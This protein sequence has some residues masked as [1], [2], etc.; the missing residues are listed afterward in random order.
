MTSR[1]DKEEIEDRV[2]T[3][4][5][6]AV[7]SVSDASIHSCPLL[8]SFESQANSVLMEILMEQD[9]HREMEWE[10]L[11]LA[12]RRCHWRN[13]QLDSSTNL[14]GWLY[15]RQRAAFSFSQKMRISVFTSGGSRRSETA[16]RR[17]EVWTVVPG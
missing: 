4:M 2:M 5:E 10:S 6:A 16:V 3:E 8:T 9:W 14:S 7:A 11:A 13:H 15:V 1:S 12:S 17:G